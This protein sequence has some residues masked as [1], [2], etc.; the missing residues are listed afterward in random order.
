MSAT[1]S[2]SRGRKLWLRCCFARQYES[3]RSAFGAWVNLFLRICSFWYCIDHCFVPH[4]RRDHWPYADCRGLI[5][6][7]HANGLLP[8]NRPGES[9]ICP[10]CGAAAQELGKPEVDRNQSH[11]RRALWR[12]ADNEK[13]STVIASARRPSEQNGGMN[14]HRHERR[15][16]R[17]GA[18]PVAIQEQV[19]I[20][21]EQAE[22]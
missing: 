14:E 18:E 6:P 15:D 17:N 5:S 22:S 20:C 11:L 3:D 7:R 21:I 9:R 12:S 2:T 4:T 8:A 13:F 10:F 16:S 1:P 19:T